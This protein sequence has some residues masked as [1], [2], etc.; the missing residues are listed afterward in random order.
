MI[1]DRF[2]G[3]DLFYT[4]CY[5]TTSHNGRLDLVDLDYLDRDHLICPIYLI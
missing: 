3:L 4:A 5:N 1:S 2:A